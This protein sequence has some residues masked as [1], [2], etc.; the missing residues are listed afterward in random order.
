[1][2]TTPSHLTSI[3]TDLQY[4]ES[5]KALDYLVAN[6]SHR[7]SKVAV[8]IE[9]LPK[10]SSELCREAK[11]AALTYSAGQRE[12]IIAGCF[13]VFRDVYSGRQRLLEY[14]IIDLM[15]TVCFQE[16]RNYCGNNEISSLFVEAG[17]FF[18]Q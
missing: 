10:L 6:Y 16:L 5:N 14:C 12:N 13:R 1:M 17:A 2:A 9:L 15:L 18:N 11:D 4:R 8:L 3:E 7:N